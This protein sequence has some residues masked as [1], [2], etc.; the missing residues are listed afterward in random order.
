M[1]VFVCVCDLTALLNLFSGSL[2]NSVGTTSHVQQPLCCVRFG[3]CSSHYLFN[4]C[5]S[6]IL[7]WNYLMPLSASETIHSFSWY[8]KFLSY[9]L[10]AELW[11]ALSALPIHYFSSLSWMS[12]FYL[13]T[14]YFIPIFS[15][16]LCVFISLLSCLILPDFASFL[17]LIGS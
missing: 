15:L 9:C 1:C 7:L 3:E 16:E 13:L 4:R 12:T 2:S 11:M 6:T 10:S 14:A 5:L 17:F 8:F